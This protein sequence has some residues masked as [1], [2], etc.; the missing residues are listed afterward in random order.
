M[1]VP[2]SNR[3]KAVFRSG[4]AEKD[5]T[6]E[7]EEVMTEDPKLTTRDLA[8]SQPGAGADDESRER[9]TDEVPG[10]APIG[11]TPT[12][13]GDQPSPSA[14]EPVLED[15][16]GDAGAA[17][18]LEG[19]DARPEGEPL[20]PADQTERFVDR[21][22]EI[23]A[24]FVDRPRES[25]EEADLLVADLMQRLAASFSNERERLEGQWDKGDDV[26]TEELRVVLTRYRSFFDRLL[27][28]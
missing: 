27:A 5:E 28:A 20:L 23:Q 18:E 25:V 26:S 13:Q 14:E 12:E 8:G 17:D 16:A 7:M 21:W 22:E 9:G 4:M 6:R 24:S 19:A 3:A 11:Q 10:E 1:R 2:V 15:Q